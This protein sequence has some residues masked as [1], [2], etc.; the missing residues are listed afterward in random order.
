MYVWETKEDIKLATF[1]S[2][3][4]VYVEVSKKYTPKN[5]L[6]GLNDA[7]KKAEIASS[8]V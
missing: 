7:L 3:M 8:E 6:D 2:G 4:I 1:Q 5:L